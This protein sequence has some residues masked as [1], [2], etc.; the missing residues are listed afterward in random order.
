MNNELMNVG[1][2]VLND[3]YVLEKL[4]T[5]ESCVQMLEN[6]DILLE[7]LAEELMIQQEETDGI[8]VK[9]T[10]EF[11]GIEIPNIYGGFGEGKKAITDKHI[12]E[13]HDMKLFHI[14]E[15]IN[16]N[17]KRFK[18]GIDYI[19]L[20]HIVL[21]DTF[22]KEQLGFTKAQI[23]NSKNIY[24][25]S[26][27]G[28][29]K[30][31]KIMDTD[32]AWEIHDKLI[33]EYFQMKEMIKNGN[34]PS[35][36][37]ED[38]E[39][40]AFAWIRERK[41]EKYEQLKLFRKAVE[42]RMEKLIIIEGNLTFSQFNRVAVAI[43][44]EISRVSGE[45]IPDVWN[46][47]YNFLRR[48]HGINLKRR[49]NNQWEKINIEREEN[50]KEPYKESTLKTKCSKLSTIKEDEYVKIIDTP[51]TE[52][53]ERTIVFPKQLLPIL[54]IMKQVSKSGYVVEGNTKYGAEVRS[55]QRTFDRMLDRIGI[56]HKGFHSLR[57]T[58]ATRAL[59]CGMDV[60]TLSV[61]LGHKNP[62]ITLK[63]Y[64]HSMTEH[65]IDMMNKIGKLLD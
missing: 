5:I 51:K 57:H 19:D 56:E 35:Y 45:K 54:K 29:A 26:E 6:I 48:K 31:I 49:Q 33:D 21:N 2:N 11:M 8:S 25:L 40:R 52:T 27:R 17:I 44:E 20:K 34:L 13:V 4:E 32:L 3:N 64:A 36:Q 7:Q 65:R 1:L 47:I 43:V 50:G 62:T 41:R 16:R 37:I 38:E 23:G 53:S 60:K 55:Y 15:L 61:T 30:L 63:R 58:F 42:E 24:L 22:L 18:E 10:T 9:G 12:A 39:T 46:N 59:E 28:Y 14:R